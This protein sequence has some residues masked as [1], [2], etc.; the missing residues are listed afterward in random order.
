M[1]SGCSSTNI[2][3]VIMANPHATDWEECIEYIVLA[4]VNL[5]SGRRDKMNT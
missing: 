3:G 1:L 4:K 2:Y 5:Q